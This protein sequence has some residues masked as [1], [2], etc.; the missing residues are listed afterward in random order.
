MFYYQLKLIVFFIPNDTVV[1]NFMKTKTVIIK[2]YFL[3]KIPGRISDL[4][5]SFFYSKSP[6]RS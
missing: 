2:K 5:A 4:T 6:T 3:K 1:S